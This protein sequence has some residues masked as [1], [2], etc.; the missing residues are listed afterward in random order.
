MENNQH[1]HTNPDDDLYFAE[2]IYW[3]EEDEVVKIELELEAKDKEKSKVNKYFESTKPQDS[4]P[5]YHEYTCKPDSIVLGEDMI[6]D[7]PEK[8]YQD[9]FVIDGNSP[10]FGDARVHCDARF[11]DNEWVSGDVRVHGDAR[12]YGNARVYTNMNSEEAELEADEYGTEEAKLEEEKELRTI[13]DRERN[14]T[15][16]EA[17]LSVNRH[18]EFAFHNILNAPTTEIRIQWS[19]IMTYMASEAEVI[20]NMKTS[21]S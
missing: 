20:R 21:L 5:E 19:F 4:K 9:L 16:E 18:A 1:T 13:L 15:L 3:D 11:Y 14:A 10:I 8:E 12:V 17:A 6:V 7:V 2:K